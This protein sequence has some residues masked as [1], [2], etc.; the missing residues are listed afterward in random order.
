MRPQVFYKYREDSSRTGEIITKGMVW[1][2]TAEGLNDPLECRT[3]KIPDEWKRKSI[4]EME[5]AQMGGFVMSAMPA[6][7]GKQ[8]FYSLSPRATKRWFQGLKRLKT[9]KEKYAKIRSFLK[10]HGRDISRPAEL[11]E[12]FEN[13][14]SQAG[15]FSL[16]E[17][18]DNELMWAHYASSHIGLALGFRAVPGS[19][20]ASREHTMQVVYAKEKPTFKEGFINQVSMI[21]APDGGLRS[22]QKI[23]FNDP[24]FRAAF[25]TKPP[26]WSYEKEWRY[27]EETGGSFPWPGPIATLV[28]GFKM[29]NMRRKHYANLVLRSAPNAVEFFEI[30]RSG[31]NSSFVMAPWRGSVP[32]RS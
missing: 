16:S 15:I 31:D 5:N 26:A 32:R 25:S 19:K 3:G 30:A 14:L 1:L 10:D 4:R 24:T 6:L 27:V 7:K 20:L 23:G 18:P 21:T 9:R 2:A 28:F 22:E 8:S 17:C 29:P 11:F 12:K 13:Q